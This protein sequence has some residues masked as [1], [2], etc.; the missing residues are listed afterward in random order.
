ME[1]VMLLHNFFCATM[2]IEINVN[3]VRYIL[4]NTYMPDYRHKEEAYSNEY[5]KIL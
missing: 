3:S 4:N 1:K 2:G 5:R